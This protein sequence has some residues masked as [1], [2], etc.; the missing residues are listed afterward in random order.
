MKIFIKTLGCKV[1][2]YE[3][4]YIMDSFIS[5]GY[6]ITSNE[7]LADVIIINTCSVTNMADNKSKKFIRQARKNTNACLVVCGC[8]SQNHQNE[9]NNLGINI[10]LGNKNKSKIVEYVEKYFENKENISLFYD[11]RKTEFEDMELNNLETKTRAFVKIQDGCNNYCSY[12]IIPYLRGGI[13]YKD[14]NTAV[15]EICSLVNKGHKEIV[16]TGIHTGSYGFDTNYDLV[17]LIN[18]ISK[19]KEL[20]RI[21]IS[22]IE[23]TELNDKFMD[24]LKNNK[25]VCDHLHIPLQSGSD[26][27]LKLMNRKYDTKYFLDKINLIRSIRPLINITTDVIVG[28]PNETDKLFNETYELCKK[29]K[30]GKIH[31]FP[32]SV[33][34]GTKAAL[35]ENQVDESIKK[36]RNRLLIEL[37]DKMENEYNTQFLNK[38][39][40]IISET[41]NSGFTSN[42]IKIISDKDL[43]PNKKYIMEITKVEGLNTYGSFK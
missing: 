21:R 36:E 30:F 10:M 25:K 20:E 11:L 27:I 14:F 6:E 18:E 41:T 2:F 35:M 26:E 3:S 31:C 28:F 17:D 1:N 15:K 19:F 38:K 5:K 34:S 32:Y 16:L 23:I 42:Y 13:R 12:C 4:E 7:E 29:I 39:L 22:S 8:S 9:Y 33:R 24:L 43:I 37:S 40:E